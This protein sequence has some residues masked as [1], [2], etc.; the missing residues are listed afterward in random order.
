MAHRSNIL[1]LASKISM[2]GMTYTGVTYTDP[3]YRILEPIIDDDMCTIMMHLKL[4][5]NRTPEEIARRAGRSLEFTQEQLDK[6]VKTGAVRTREVDGVLCYYYPIWVPGIMEGILSNREQCDI[7]PELGA[8]FEEYTRRRLAILVPSAAVGM[9]F[10]RIIPVEAAIKNNTRAAG[11]DELS[12]LIEN[13]KAISVGPCSCRRSRRLMGEGCGHLEEDMCMY[14]N[15]N[16][17]CYSKSGAHRLITKEEAY[18]ILKRAEDN[19]LMHELNQSEGFGNTSA[20]CNCCECSC[21]ALRIATYFN[22]PDS[23][24]SNYVATIDSSLCT[25]CG[26]CVENCQSNALQLGKKLRSVQPLPEPAPMAKPADRIWTSKNYNVEYRT[27]RRDT[28]EGGTSP[29]KAMCPAHVPVQAVLKLVEEGRDGDALQLLKKY[30]PFPE[31]CGRICDRPCEK[32]CT[33]GRLD[34]PLS[35]REVIAALAMRD[36]EE[37]TRSIPVITNPQG[38]AYPEKI[39]VIGAGP[40]GLSCAY[41]LATMGY[42]VTVIDR[43]SEAGG[44]VT[45]CIPRF[46]Y[47]HK[48][49]DAEIQILKDLGVTFRFGVEVGTD[50]DFPTLRKEGFKAF[51]LGIGAGLD[52]L[53]KIPGTY[54]SGVV[55]AL[56]FLRA[57]C[58][59]G[60]KPAVGE[61]VTVLGGGYAAVDAARAAIRLGAKQVSVIAPAVKADKSQA[62][63]EGV[64]FLT[65]Y[66][67]VKIN[68]G[69]DRSVL[70]VTAEKLGSGDVLDVAADSVI[71]ATGQSIG[72][73]QIAESIKL[74]IKSDGTLSTDKVT[75]QTTCSDVFAAGDVIDSSGNIIRAIA[76]GREAALSIHRYVHRGQDLR[77]GRDNRDYKAFDVKNTVFPA[78]AKSAPAR[79][80]PKPLSL[81]HALRGFSYAEPEL[82]EAQMRS[83][84]SRCLG[85][86]AVQLNKYMCLGC[87]IC[88]TKCA[89]GAISLKK[90]HDEPGTS[91]YHTLMRV[92]GNAG[93]RFTKLAVKSVA[94]AVEN[95]KAAGKK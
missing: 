34:S 46:R 2:E 85:C 7:Y 57:A 91:Y 92:A 62:I 54:L 75:Y 82:T 53:P 20:I 56:R 73:R 89:F 27:N 47:N 39:A 88:T 14:L 31:L 10:M 6:L 18:E 21:F 55:G 24:R 41:Y 52:K 58:A 15:D 69:E 90:V 84:C 49:L 25:A 29:C 50:T 87:G 59:P 3:E 51:F 33:R 74:D 12:T 78:E 11:Y 23:I 95:V 94:K 30:M 76:G 66:K 48:V 80:E 26:Q 77:I 70:S 16:A 22:T 35:I 42:S 68:G 28:A 61:K 43:A 1:K 71:C 40:A 37:T 86:G 13:A 72:L 63:R 4:N 60:K 44:M 8:A 83:E 79:Q 9:S 38:V 32:A 45:Q 36:L 17:I 65:P 81:S 93:K 19:G 67:F 64:T 5:T